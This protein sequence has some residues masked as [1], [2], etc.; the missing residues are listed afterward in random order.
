MPDI[1]KPFPTIVTER[2]I[3]RALKNSDVAEICYLRS[4]AI[5]NKYS[6]RP[7]TKTH[8]EAIEFIQMINEGVAEQKR[9]YWSICLKEFPEKLIGTICLWNYSED[10]LTAEVGYDLGTKF[11]QKGIMSEALKA[12]LQYGIKEMKFV[13]IEAFTHKNNDASKKLLEKHQF[14]LM[15]ERVDKTNKDNSIYVLNTAN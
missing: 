5:V 4:D 2:L 1:I 11:H 7:L 10:M 8:E 14:K 3:L 13:T 15:N 9:I 6:K 12:V